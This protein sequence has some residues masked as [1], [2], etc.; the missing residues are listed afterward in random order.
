MKIFKKLIV[1]LF[2]LVLYLYVANITLMPKNIII[3]QG[4]N[5]SVS[6][7]WG[8]NIKQ[9]ATTNPNLGQYDSNKLGIEQVSGG[10]DQDKQSGTIDL[11]VNILDTIPLKNIK[12]SVIPKT[13]VIP[14]GNSIGMK[15][16]TKGVL[17]VG[18]SEIE[19]TKPY[20]NSGI[21][22]GDRI[23]QINDTE[24]TCTEDLV[25]TVNNSNGNQ[26]KIK[27][28]KDENETTMVANMT[29]AKT[30]QDEYKLGLWVRDA[31][32]GVGTVTFYQ[33][34]TG[35]FASLGHGI[36]DVDTGGLVK[37]AKGELVTANILS[38]VKGKNGTPGE[39]RGTIDGGDKLGEVYNNT[40][41]GIFGKLSS[42]NKLDISSQ[43]EMEVLS[44]DKVKTGKAQI[45]CEIENGNRKYYDIE[46]KRV[47]TNNNSDNKSMLIK[48]TDSE[49]L[50]KT[51][52]IV[53]GMSGSPI[54]QD[55]KFVGAVTHVLV[56]DPT[57]GY[58]VFADLMLK[59]MAS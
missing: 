58:G 39:L 11:D 9:I 44:R 57:T 24:I 5:L 17:V 49:L 18:M 43:N 41:F 12:V 29:P 3:M 38:I 2:L 33:P 37:I 6:T 32:A 20:E 8:V 7:L 4:E 1:L 19:G 48:V 10:I 34:S 47:Y 55:G 56:N 14:L 15:L 54:I 42:T 27:Y 45:I 51:G 26:L 35:K 22:E 13:T 36:T 21:E 46:I 52:G 25:Q 31:A 30:K 40:S 50:E 59:E 53:Q 28:I 23:V 16:Y